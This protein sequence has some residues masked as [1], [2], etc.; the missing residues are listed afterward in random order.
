MNVV[1][2]SCCVVQK[3]ERR[4]EGGR[5]WP[6][7]VFR[8]PAAPPKEKERKK[9]ADRKVPDRA[10]VVKGERLQKKKTIWKCFKN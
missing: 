8:S 2:Y 6:G 7:K 4:R 1:L 9:Q 3:G 5:G 10:G